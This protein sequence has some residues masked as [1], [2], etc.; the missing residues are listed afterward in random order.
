MYRLIEVGK[1][2]F[3]NGEIWIF[4]C[5]NC[6]HTERVSA[7]YAKSHVKFCVNCGEPAEVLPEI[8]KNDDGNTSDKDRERLVALLKRLEDKCTNPENPSYSKYET[9]QVDRD[10]IANPESFIAWAM[11][12]GYRSWRKLYRVDDSKDYCPDNCYWSAQ[13]RKTYDLT[14]EEWEDLNERLIEVGLNIDTVA[15][16]IKEL[17]LSKDELDEIVNA[18]TSCKSKNKIANK[19]DSLLQK[20]QTELKQVVVME[21][22][23][24]YMSDRQVLDDTEVKKVI[25]EVNS[26]RQGL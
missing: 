17:R 8:K 23:Y 11:K 18:I 12:N 15:K 4:K 14:N 21:Q 22:A 6:G 7:S 10:W 25:G 5:D 16:N 20:V 2:K 26:I 9:I 24:N 1:S 13:K 19:I 3:G